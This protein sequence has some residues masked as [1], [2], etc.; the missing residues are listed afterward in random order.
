M[1]THLFL[2]SI[3]LL[4]ASSA[5]QP[6]AS[7]DGTSLDGIGDLDGDGFDDV[8]I[9]DRFAVRPGGGLGVVEVRSGR[10]GAVIRTVEPTGPQP[11][12]GD[13]VASAGDLDGDGV[14]ELLVS[15]FRSQ[16]PMRVHAF[17]GATGTE[18]FV[19]EHGAPPFVGGCET[20]FGKALSAAGDVNG[21]GVGD[22]AIGAPSASGFCV[23]KLFLCSGSDGSLLWQATGRPVHVYGGADQFGAPI[24]Q[25]GDLDGDGVSELAVGAP[26]FYGLAQCGFDVVSGA[27]GQLVRRWTDAVSICSGAGGGLGPLGDVD[28]D[29]V[30]DMWAA[31]P[32]FSYSEVGHAQAFSGATG[33]P[34]H[35]FEVDPDALA[36]TGLALFDFGLSGR[37]IGDMDG[38]GRPDV[39]LLWW[40]SDSSGTHPIQSAVSVHRGH[41]GEHLFDLTGNGTFSSVIDP[42]AVG[43][44]DGDGFADI[45]F[46][47][48]MR[49]QFQ[50]GNEGSAVEIAERTPANG[51][52]ICLGLANSTGASALLRTFSPSGFSAAANDLTLVASRLP[53]S[54]FG[55][56]SVSRGTA[57]VYY[58]GG[59]EGRYCIGAP[60][61]G[62]LD[63]VGA[64]A[65]G[66]VAFSPD[67]TQIPMFSAAGATYVSA[68]AGDT[69]NFQLWY[70]DV[71][72]GGPTSNFSAA[73][74]VTFQ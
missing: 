22:F 24:A 11:S 6:L 31:V 37:T 67:L 62:R 3:A 12:F 53:A 74:G 26:A 25:V 59:S 48:Q 39:A 64:T 23:G 50:H 32:G 17:D 44:V 65:E 60:A 66:D 42:R 30:P 61:S 28:G 4:G 34:L 20:E 36:A 47:R 18:L 52:S 1:R 54:T 16:A 15:S 8:V 14:Q 10:T 58:P 68:V 2:A 45:G 43:D 57:V 56:F 40:W 13:E 35:R 29:G 41:D 27:T 9:A 72:P 33:A 21:D 63:I 69:Y 46:V 7:H 70:R 19:V 73:V 49:G 5:Q 55:L 38:D 71:G 51:R